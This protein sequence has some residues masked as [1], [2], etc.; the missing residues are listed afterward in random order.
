[1]KRP[2]EM[3]I[4]TAIDHAAVTCRTCLLCGAESGWAAVWAPSASMGHLFKPGIA[5]GYS[6]CD[7]CK[8]EDDAQERVEAVLCDQWGDHRL[9]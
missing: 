9:N 6:L 8:A 3:R 2:P 1:M 5:F 4:R 7:T